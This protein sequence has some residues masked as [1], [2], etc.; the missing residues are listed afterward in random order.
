MPI[1]APMWNS[2]PEMV[3]GLASARSR[4]SATRRAALREVDARAHGRGDA[5][6]VVAQDG[7]APGDDAALAVLGQ[8]RALVDGVVVLGALQEAQVGL[9]RGRALVGGHDRLEPVAPDQLGL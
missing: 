8:H 4:P 2:A 7:V 5:A 1:E 6:L 9:V 3:K